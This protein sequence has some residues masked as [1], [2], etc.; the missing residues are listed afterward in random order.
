MFVALL[1]V[2]AFAGCD[3]NPDPTE[4]TF[5][6]RV[7]NDTSRPVVVSDCAT[8]DGACNGHH[9]DPVRV[10]PGS[11]LSDV[12][13]SIGAVDVELISSM[14]GKRLGCLPLY[15]DYNASGKTVNVSEMVP[16][17]TTYPVRAKGV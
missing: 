5:Y 6:V 3:F 8:G 11:S 17:R 9:Y 10:T 7:T 15:F 14:S 1:A 16:C 4:A 12:Q 13:T 2:P